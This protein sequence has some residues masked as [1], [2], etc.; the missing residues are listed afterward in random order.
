MYGLFLRALQN[1]V[2]F[3]FGSETL[4]QVLSVAC[5]PVEGFEPLLRYDKATLRA[6][7]AAVAGQLGRPADA[8]LEDLGTF[9]ITQEELSPARR[10]LRFGG[11]T[12]GDFL[13]SLEE[14]PDRVRLALADEDFPPLHLTDLGEGRFRLVCETDCAEI[15]YVLLGILRAMADDYGALVVIEA[16][17]QYPNAA[18][19]MICLLDVRFAEGRRF[20]LVAEEQT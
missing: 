3:T 14:L 18:A 6:F 7:I 13:F 11:A 12:F 8:I 1:Y 19:L 5:A 16:E 2:G 20:D 15:E 9:V 4:A 17:P 10:L